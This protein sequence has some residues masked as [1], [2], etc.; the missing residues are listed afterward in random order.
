MIWMRSLFPAILLLVTGCASAESLLS[1]LYVPVPIKVFDA[2]AYDAD[3][4]MCAAAGLAWKPQFSLGSAL[5]K[6]IDGATSNTSMIP[7]SPLVPAYGAAGG[8]L[9][10]A[11]DGLDLMSGQHNRVYKHCLTDALRLDGAA[12]V[13]DPD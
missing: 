11:S 10:A 8:A 4:A 5:G 12:I 9:G 1:P 2:A 3:V 6:T 7:I 13:A